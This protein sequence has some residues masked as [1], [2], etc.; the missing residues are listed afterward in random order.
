MINATINIWAVLASG[1]AQMV[2]GFLWYNPA[3]FGTMWMKASG[4]KMEDMEAKKG[5]MPKIYALSFLLALV[6][7]AVL[8]MILKSLNVASLG[9][10]LFAT[11]VI[12]LGIQVTTKLNDVLFGGKSTTWFLIDV[13]HNLAALLVTSVIVTLWA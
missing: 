6:T 7:S 9:D 11:T 1:V 13:G 2:V 8:A 10:A 4:I 3:L 12:W 5:D